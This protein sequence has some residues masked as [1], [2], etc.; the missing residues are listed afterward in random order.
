M[1]LQTRPVISGNFANQPSAKLYKLNNNNKRFLEAEKV[2]K[3][4]FVIGLPAKKIDRKSI[5][6]ITRTLLSIDSL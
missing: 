3:L 5:N 6:F 1:G 2:Q 4:G